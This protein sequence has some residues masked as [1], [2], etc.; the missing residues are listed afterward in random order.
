MAA[1]VVHQHFGRRPDA[2]HFG[3]ASL[4]YNV[5]DQRQSYLQKVVA[6]GLRALGYNEQADRS[7]HFSYEMVTL[8]PKT[9][10]LLG[11][12]LSAEEQEKT[13]VEMSGRKGIGVKADDLID[14]LRDSALDRIAE[15]YKTFSPE[16]RGELASNVAVAALRYFMIRY[17]RNT[18][19]NFDMDE[20][21]SF[22]GETGPYLQ[23]SMVRARSIFRKLRESGFDPDAVKAEE[24]DRV[25]SMVSAVND[26]EASDTWQILIQILRT[27]EV[28]HRALRSLEL[29]YFAKHVF[30]IA[31]SFNNYYHKYPVL[32]EKDADRRLLRVATVR[33]FQ[34]GMQTQLELLGIPVP[35]RM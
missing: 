21:L 22:E 35:E 5:I 10:K 2:P 25:L 9:A 6:E 16:E 8:S 13:F 31:R 14:R 28:V 4:V 29:S 3:G 30:E 32:H 24:Y 26:E 7:I 18:I 20:A 19:I 1:F 23:Y 15:L 12:E 34:Q 33:M 27:P 17:T 11:F